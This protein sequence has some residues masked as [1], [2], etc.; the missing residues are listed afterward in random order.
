MSTPPRMPMAPP[1]HVGVEFMWRGRT[2]TTTRARVV[3]GAEVWVASQ[4]RDVGTGASCKI[5]GWIRPGE[6]VVTINDGVDA[7]PQHAR[8]LALR[9][10]PSAEVGG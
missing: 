9:L 8:L 1:S 7:T 10:V 5:C 4:V 3:Y 2:V 6:S